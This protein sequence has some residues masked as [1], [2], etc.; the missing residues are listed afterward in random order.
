MLDRKG[1]S[2]KI[3]LN[4]KTYIQPFQLSYKTRWWLQPRYSIIT[5]YA[6]VLFLLLNTF[7]KTSC[8]IS[9][10][11]Q[12]ICCSLLAATLSTL[13]MLSKKVY[14]IVQ[15]YW[16]MNL[17]TQSFYSQAVPYR[18]IWRRPFWTNIISTLTV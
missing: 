5:T 18:T 11:H 15:L 17:L 13:N 14:I 6:Y 3:L 7:S 16:L 9:F 10:W 2:Y 8:E 12:I 1:I 4:R